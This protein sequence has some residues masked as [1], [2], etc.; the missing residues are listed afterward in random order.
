M[1]LLLLELN[2]EPVGHA[3]HSLG[4]K[5]NRHRQ[6]EVSGPKL[7]IDLSVQRFL[8]FFTQHGFVF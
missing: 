8:H 2:G 4:G 1:I 7:R 6:I 5:V 3:L